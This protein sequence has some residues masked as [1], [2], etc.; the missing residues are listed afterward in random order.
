MSAVV[1][2]RELRGFSEA[3]EKT[4]LA[5]MDAAAIAINEGAELA[6]KLGRSQILRELNLEV[7]YVH[8]HL[9]FHDEAHRSGLSARVGATQRS[10][11]APRYGASQRLVSA[12]SDVRRLKGDPYRGIAKGQKGAGS[13]AWSVKRGGAKKVWKNAFFVKLKSSGAWALV[14]RYGSG[15]GMKTKADWRA[16][17]KVV[18][19]LS[20]A[21]AW[22]S[23]RD[24]VAP[25]AMD[26][27]EKVFFKELEK[28][29]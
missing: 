18:Q 8:K 20:V 14:A 5:A 16:N 23:V 2:A 7:A 26:L 9:V 4:P 17:L 1:F 11:L 10:V 13:T 25:Q 29:L 24:D 19:S 27:A 21:Q 15:A 12:S 22:L 3:L 6:L 28:R